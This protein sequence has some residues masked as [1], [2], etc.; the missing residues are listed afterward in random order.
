MDC[1][2]LLEGHCTA[3][4]TAKIGRQIEDAGYYKPT[5]QEQRMF[6]KNGGGIGIPDD[7]TYC[8]RYRA[9]LD[10]LRAKGLEK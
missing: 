8:R 5:E 9:Y 1:V 7:F 10:Y 3:Q 4:S 2:Y 6:C